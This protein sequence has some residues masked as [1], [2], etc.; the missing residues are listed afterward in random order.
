MTTDG[1][2]P[3]DVRP[4]G[5]GPDE[6]SP[7]RVGRPAARPAESRL[8]ADGNSSEDENLKEPAPEPP[9]T[10]LPADGTYARIDLGALGR[11]LAA[12]RRHAGERLV[13]LPVKANAY[14]HGLI[15]IAKA[16]AEHGW[17]DWLGVA[18]V[19]EGAALREAGVKLP[20]LK[21]SAAGAQTD[22]AI[23]CGLTL[24]V[25]DQAE[26][27]AAESAAA[28]QGRIAA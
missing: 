15:P 3:D 24:T 22:A 26:T 20:I 14:G 5:P 28:R 2:T 4:S 9:P 12:L 16:A 7:R 25:S 1:H 11:N 23:A 8:Q 18:T 6:P 17:A 10:Q 19:A 27:Q 21:L 13:L